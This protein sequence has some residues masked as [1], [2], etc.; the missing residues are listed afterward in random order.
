MEARLPLILLVLA[1]SA[2]ATKQS[3]PTAGSR[4]I[5]T[6]EE[7]RDSGALTAY[8]AV[9]DLRPRFLRPGRFNL[10]GSAYPIVYVD[11]MRLGEVDELR[12]IPTSD[13]LTIQY[14]SPPD[15]T[16]R[17]GTG[18]TGGALLVTTRGR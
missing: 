18:H 14:L 7:I 9:R 4:N 13:V 8:Q 16:T 15:A 17:F 3:S 11:D 6:S 5:I 10:K 2:C 1:V 12:R